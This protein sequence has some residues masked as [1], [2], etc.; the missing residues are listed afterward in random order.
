MATSTQVDQKQILGAAL[1]EIITGSLSDET[2]SLVDTLKLNEVPEPLREMVNFMHHMSTTQP[3]RYHV[4][5][6]LVR[7]IAGS[8]SE[9]A[10]QRA[11]N[12][13]DVVY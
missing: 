10:E 7:E 12:A 2:I 6:H 11:K 9:V 3:L 13:P 4:I 8:A 5:T 1:L